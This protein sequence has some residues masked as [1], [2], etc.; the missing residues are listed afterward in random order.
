MRPDG[1]VG[2]EAASTK[3]SSVC[4]AL[5]EERAQLAGGTKEVK[6]TSAESWARG[7]FGE[8]DTSLKAFETMLWTL[9]FI[10]GSMGS[11]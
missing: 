4:Q 11:H 8:M 7:K 6:T 1:G 5:M 9:D 10:L 2:R 3:E